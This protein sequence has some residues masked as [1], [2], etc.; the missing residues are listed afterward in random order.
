MSIKHI[1]NVKVDR[2]NPTEL[3]IHHFETKPIPKVVDLRSKMP[4]VYEQGDLGSSTANALVGVVDSMKVGLKG[5][6]L[7]AYYNERRLD[8][9]LTETTVNTLSEGVKSLEKYGLCSEL[10]YPYT[11]KSANVCPPKQCYTSASKISTIRS[12]NVLNDLSQ[13]KLALSSNTPIVVAIQ[14]YDSFESDAVAQTGMVPMPQV[15]EQLLGGHSVVV[16]GF[17]DNRQHFIVRNSWGPNWGDRGYFYLPYLYLLDSAI[18]SDLW[19][20]VVMPPETSTPVTVS[21]GIPLT[22]APQ[23]VKPRALGTPPKKIKPK[24]LKKIVRLQKRINKIQRK[25]NHLQK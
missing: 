2:K 22:K 18:S 4:P 23:P 21:R 9:I 1:Y 11:T 24:K 5:S 16:C 8:H 7:F 15:K 20:I 10:E 3:K 14:V 25:I 19:E 12:R 13:I 6:R 17:D